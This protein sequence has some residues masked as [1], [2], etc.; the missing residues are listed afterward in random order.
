MDAAGLRIGVDPLDRVFVMENHDRAYY[1]WRDAGLKHR[2]LIHIDAHHDMWSIK[3]TE[4]ITI[5][6]FICRALKEDLVREV[7]WVVPDPA[8]GGEKNRKTILRHLR[9]LKKTYPG[10]HHAPQVRANQISMVVLGKPVRVCTLSSLPPVEE[11]VLLDIDSD[12][13]VIPRVS[14]G[15]SD[16][17][18]PLPWCWPQELLA[19]LRAR[20]IRSDSVTIAYS[21]EGGFTPL[22]WKYL[23]DELA[24]R[25]RRPNHSEP[26]IQGM[27]LIREAATAAHRGDFVTAEGKYHEARDHLP[28][29]PAPYYHLAHLYVEMGRVDDGQKCYQRALTLD[30]SYRTPY[31]NSGLHYYWNRRFREAEGEYLRALALDPQDPYA[32]LGMGRLAIQKK[33]WGEAEALLRKSLTLDGHLTDAYRVLGDVLVKQGRQE[34]AIAAYEHSLKLALAGHKPLEEPIATFLGGDNLFFDSDHCR[35][36]ARLAHLYALKGAISEAINGYRISIAGKYDGV[37]LRSRLARLYL[38]KNQ[39][40]QSALETWQAVKLIPGDLM[41]AGRRLRRHLRLRIKSGLPVGRFFQNL[42]KDGRGSDC[43]P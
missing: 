20:S 29:S 1:I 30:P 21:V 18:A 14:S 43:R 36:H 40:Q 7:Y 22:K 5:A 35:I 28:T 33:R 23:G 8:W 6:N 34:E 13:L 3:D 39:W 4:V 9:G 10:A 2:I 25:L 17:Q 12:F 24:L 15:E 16:E 32:H 19:R 26:I 42:K 37:L 27:G 38:K 41:K 31:N 11:S